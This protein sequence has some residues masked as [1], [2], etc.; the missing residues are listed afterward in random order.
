MFD[1]RSADF[2]TPHSKLYPAVLEMM[3]YA[4]ATVSII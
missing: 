1:M 4:D 2:G 3:E